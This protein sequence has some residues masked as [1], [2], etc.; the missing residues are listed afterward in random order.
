MVRQGLELPHLEAFPRQ[1]VSLL[2]QL[3]QAKGSSGELAEARRIAAGLDPG[4]VLERMLL[5]WLGDW[6]Q[7]EAAWTAARDRDARSGDRLDGTLNGYWLGRVRR[8]LGATEAAEAALAEGLTVA[9]QGPQ[10]PAEVML[11]AELALLA[12]GTGRLEAARAE[13][14]RCQEVVRSGEDWRGLAGR[15]ALT[16]GVLAAADGRSREAD[17]AFASAVRTFRAYACSWDEA[18]AR[19]LWDQALP[20]RADRQGGVAAGLYRRMGAGRRWT[21][22]AAEPVT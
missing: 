19:S 3:G 5:Y 9:M 8:L 2:D 22:W 21:A 7:A 1:R 20:A 14:A 11:R 18:E 16:A 6:E 15:V 12:V 10:V 13:L 4:T 17:E